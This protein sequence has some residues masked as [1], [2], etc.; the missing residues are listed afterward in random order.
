MKLYVGNLPYNTSENP[1]AISSRATDT[2]RA[3]GSA[4]PAWDPP[5]GYGFVQMPDARMRRRRSPCSTAFS[6]RETRSASTG[7]ETE[8]PGIRAPSPSLRLFEQLIISN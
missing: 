1:S 2:C 7:R 5:H 3:F 4:T 8:L 6:S